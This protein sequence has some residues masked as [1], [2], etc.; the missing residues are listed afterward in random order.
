MHH[1][2]HRRA[3]GAVLLVLG[4]VLAACGGGD[5]SDDAVVEGDS[6]FAEDDASGSDDTGT[7][8]DEAAVTGEADP[9]ATFVYAYPITVSRLDPHRA[10]I[11]Q[12][13]TTLFP[14]YDRLVHL[15]PDGELIPGLAESWEFS[16]DGM[17]LTLTIR[18]GVTFHDGAALDAE[19]VKTNL[20]RAI[21]IEGSSVA[22]DLRSVESVTVVDPTT[23]E[24]ALTEANVAILGSLADRAGIQVSP[25]AIADG[26]NLDEE[27]VGAGPYRMVEHTPGATTM[28]ERNDDYWDQDNLAQVAE[29][30]IRVIADQVARLNALATGQ[31]DATTVGASQV[32]EAEGTDGVSVTLNTEL[33]YMYI[34]QNRSRAQQDQLEVRQALMHGL[35]R[36]GI[37]E[38]LLF[39]YC[40][41]T[42]Q[43]FPPGYFAYDDSIDDV[44]YPYDPDLAREMLDEAG[45]TDLSLSMLIPAGLPTYPEVS[46]AIQAQWADLGVDVS[47]EPAEPT[48]LGELMFAQET[49][50][51]ML[52]TWGGRP[53]PSMTFIQRASAD[54]FGNPGGVTTPA[55][56]EIIAE[57]VATADP[58]ER[59]EVLR[60]GSREMAESVLEM[61]VLFPQVAYALADGV[62]FEPYLT[63]KPE[64]RQVAITR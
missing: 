22:T 31:I 61:V 6:P 14:A 59:Q 53:D 60:A 30:E 29:L 62:V 51:T 41:L 47:I 34:V 48:Q 23:V 26:V 64:F 36:E 8:D 50:D 13:G 17:T 9:D 4:L 45:A 49:A 27:M 46:E 55:M 2:S 1:R 33:Q 57:S 38:A 16:E 63:A 35:D 28:F 11:S 32:E 40:E 15:S 42:D 10:S 12:D 7:G 39:G 21:S 19:A 52:A 56:E 44:L 18:E 3:A 25:Q 54:G 24:L 20:D 37:C 5:D 43:P 58:D